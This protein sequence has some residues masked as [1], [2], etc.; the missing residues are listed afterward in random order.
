MILAN[1]VFIH[2]NFKHTPKY[3]MFVVMQII[4]KKGMT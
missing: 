2:L 1:N 3:Q 4:M